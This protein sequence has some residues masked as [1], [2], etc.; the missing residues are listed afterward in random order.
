MTVVKYNPVFQP[1]R[2]S[3]SAFVEDFFNRS[4]ADAHFENT[5]NKPFVNIRELENEFVID[6][7]A[8]G[9]TKEDF[10]I[11]LEQDQL[12][13]TAEK[14]IQ[15][16]ESSEKFTRREFNYSTFSRVF[17]LPDTIDKQSIKAKYENGLLQVHLPKA[18]QD[19]NKEKWQIAIN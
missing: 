11:D 3:L 9:L 15:S 4:L 2:N 8:P 6:L 18:M 14:H 12:K 17:T 1:M 10:K 7:A 16:E 19:T 5:Q 13:I